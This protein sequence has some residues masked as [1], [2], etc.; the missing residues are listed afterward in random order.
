MPPRNGSAKQRKMNI[1]ELFKAET[2]ITVA[3]S[4]SDLREFSL[5]LIEEGKRLAAQ[6]P[7]ED[8]ELTAREAAKQLGISVN[9]LWRWER[10]GYLK[11]HTRI[12]KRPM[13]L[14]SQLDELKMGR[15]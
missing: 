10:N 15:A 5:Y 6:Q 7:K 4:L 3:V 14:Q 11:P 1:T 12:G 13:Y 9:S 2:N 8:K